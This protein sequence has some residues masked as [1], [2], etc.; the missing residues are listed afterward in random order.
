MS[1][2]FDHMSQK[3]QSFLIALTQLCTTHDVQIS[4]SGYDGIQIWNLSEGDEPI[5][6]NGIE[7]KTNAQ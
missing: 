7:D 4:V 3:A 6:A 1:N 5:H 2:Q